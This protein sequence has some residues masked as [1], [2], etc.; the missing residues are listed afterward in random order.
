MTDR[1]LEHYELPTGEYAHATYLPD[2]TSRTEVLEWRLVAQWARGLDGTGR[3][4]DSAREDLETRLRAR[5]GVRLRR[6]WA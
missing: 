5:Y 1:I 3:T 4:Q 2:R 6:V